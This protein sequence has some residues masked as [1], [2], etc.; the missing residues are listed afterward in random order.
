VRLIHGD[1]L[2]ALAQLVAEG[3]KVDAIITDPPYGTTACKWDSV[4]PFDKMWPL[5]N[6]LIKPKGAIVLFGSE[7]FS[8]ALRMSNIKNYKYDWYWNKGQGL[9][10]V[11][12]RYRPLNDTE[13]ISV[14]GNLLAYY[15]IMENAK[16]ENIRPIN[17]GSNPSEIQGTIKIAKN[18]DGY[19]KNIRYPKTSI[20]INSRTA[21]CNSIYRLH[22]T[23]KPV[24]L[25]EYL[26]KTYTLEGETVLDFTMGSG[27]TGV[28]CKNT[29]RNFIGIELDDKYFDIATRR[30]NDSTSLF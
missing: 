4:I 27:S 14:F 18:K 20:N 22:P 16:P 5:L 30:I 8:S 29:S 2:K 12:A 7:P 10:F 17:N 25:M 13:C 19:D 9:N 21:E 24:A 6:A 15:P 3:I 23:Q 26:I 1:C 11:T 28:A